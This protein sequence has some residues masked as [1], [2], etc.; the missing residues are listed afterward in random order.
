MSLNYIPTELAA[1]CKS[2]SYSCSNEYKV[3]PFKL[4]LN[5]KDNFRCNLLHSCFE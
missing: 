4:L 5:F 1:L 3:F 2:N